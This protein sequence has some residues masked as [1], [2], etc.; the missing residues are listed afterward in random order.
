MSASPTLTLVPFTAD[1]GWSYC[2]GTAWG[3]TCESTTFHEE[4]VRA[5]QL[6]GF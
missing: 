4:G 1:D 3:D 6:Y 2:Y 5:S